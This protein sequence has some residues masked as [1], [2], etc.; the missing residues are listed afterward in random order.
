MRLLIVDDEE[1]I[2][3]YIQIALAGEEFEIIEAADGLDALT[4]VQDYGGSINLI[5]T[6]ITMP[7]MDGVTLSRAV[8]ELFPSMPIILLTGS[9]ENEWRG[10][11]PSNCPVLRKPL[12]PATLLRVVRQVSSDRLRSQQGCERERTGS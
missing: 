5:I 4:A 1:L 2:R 10:L 6:D 12:A 7:R 9:P 8:L 11:I 3:K